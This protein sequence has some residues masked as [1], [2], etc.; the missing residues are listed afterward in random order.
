[1]PMN[2]KPVLETAISPIVVQPKTPPEVTIQDGEGIPV[3]DPPPVFVDGPASPE[4]ASAP[5]ASPETA[6]ATRQP[7]KRKRKAK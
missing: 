4:I 6:S 2:F 7:P 1:M 5:A 3:I